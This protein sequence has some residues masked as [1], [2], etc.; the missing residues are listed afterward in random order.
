LHHHGRDPERGRGA[1]DGAFVMGI[2]NLVEH[3][4][5][6]QAKAGRQTHSHRRDRQIVGRATRGIFAVAVVRRAHAVARDGD[7]EA[8]GAQPGDTFV[9]EQRSVG[10]DGRLHF[11]PSRGRLLAGVVGEGHQISPAQQR[12]ATEE[13]QMQALRNAGERQIDGTAGDLDG[14]VALLLAAAVAVGTAQVAGVG[15][16]KRKVD[17]GQGVVCVQNRQHCDIIFRNGMAAN[18]KDAHVDPRRDCR[19]SHGWARVLW[20][21]LLT[22]FLVTVSAPGYAHGRAQALLAWVALLPLLAALPRLSGRQASLAGL[23]AGATMYCGWAAWMPGLMARFSGWSPAIAVLAALA[24]ALAHGAGWS[25]WSWLVRRTCSSL[26]LAL[27]APAAFVVMERWF[28]SVFPWSLGLAHYQF[29]D[30][31]QI[32]ELGGPGVLTFLEILVAAVLAQVWLA[33]RDEHCFSWRW[34]GFVV[35]VIIATLAF[36]R[37]RRTQIEA[38]RM[39]APAARIAAVQAGTVASDWRAQTA[40]DLLARYRKA[41]VDLER[42]AGRFDLVVWPEKASPVLRKDVAGDADVM[43][44]VADLVGANIDQR[45]RIGGDF[46]SPLL[47]GAETIDVSTRERWNAAALLQPDGRL[48]VVYAKV[49]LIV[50]SEWLP[51]WAERLFGRRYSRGTSNAPVAIPLATQAQGGAMQAG[52]FICFESAFA[53]QVRA[54]VAH[55]AQMLLN[56]SDDSWFGDSAE[57]EEHLAHAVFRAIESRRDMVRATG[58]GISAFITATGQVESR[59]PVAH[60]GAEVAVLTAAPRRLQAHSLYGWL[61][62]GFPLACVALTLAP[63]VLARRRRPLSG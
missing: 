30:L 57:P 8:L 25:L 6:A 5:H 60:S 49:Q 14:H 33:W 20:P 35:A 3:Q 29:R 23:I 2:G 37:V 48:H 61:G 9:V 19:A 34:P 15:Q 26:P 47:F 18:P 38:A 12:L 46:A 43:P 11:N 28:P 62:D 27:V 21:S 16:T 58:S 10:G 55:G 31:A 41:T 36:G 52:I 56:L 7:K 1:Q 22:G 32:A 40:P 50:W 63:L 24:L 54:Q 44:S 59:L 4:H 53:K 39:Q 51:P 17:V 45:R 42:A 13:D